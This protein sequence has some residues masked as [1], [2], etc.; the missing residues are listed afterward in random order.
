MAQLY[1]AAI[2]QGVDVV[3]IRLQNF[4]IQLGGFVETILQDQKLNVVFLDLNIL[5]MVAVEEAYSAVALSRS[6]LA[7]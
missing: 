4:V 6:P 1:L 2:D 5:G 7:K 3:R